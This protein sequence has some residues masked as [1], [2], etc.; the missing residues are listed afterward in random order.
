MVATKV[1][2]DTTLSQIIKLVDNASNTKAPTARLAD[3]VS[4]VFVPIVIGIDIITFAI[5][6]IS[7]ATPDFSLSMGITVLVISC[8]CALGLAT[9]VAIMAGT[10]KAAENGI[11]I[12]SA[13][14]RER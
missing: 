1:G 12:K 14:A 2:S 11:L 5:W 13:E 6:L 10:G 8:P 3:K 4:G 7:G 9:P